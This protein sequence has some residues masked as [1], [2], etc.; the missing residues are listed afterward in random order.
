VKNSK[1][2]KTK[3]E[4]DT[5]LLD[6]SIFLAYE[7]LP[8]YSY[9]VWRPRIFMVFAQSI[10]IERSKYEATNIL[11]TDAMSSGFYESSLGLVMTKNYNYFD[12]SYDLNFKKGLK[13][14]ILMGEITVDPGLELSTS[15]SVGYNPKALPLRIG[16]SIS[17]HRQSDTKFFPQ[18]FAPSFSKYY[19]SLGVNLAYRFDLFSLKL[20]YNDQSFFGKARN[21]EISQSIGLGL[22][23]FIDL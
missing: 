13:R 3:S 1:E 4:S 2:I 9:S 15:F 5:G 17:Y 6:P 19:S 11:R 12:L 21:V 22:T 20:N 23:S 16:S 18:T 7:I 14:Q 8:E 10:P